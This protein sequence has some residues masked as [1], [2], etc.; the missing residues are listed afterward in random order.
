MNL[1]M[2]MIRGEAQQIGRHYANERKTH[3]QN[4]GIAAPT[5]GEMQK[6]DRLKKLSKKRL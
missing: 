2:R 3:L 4:L 5:Q 6:S 1:L